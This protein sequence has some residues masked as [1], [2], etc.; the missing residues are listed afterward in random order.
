MD[1]LNRPSKSGQVDFNGHRV[2]LMI[3]NGML[4]QSVDEV[5]EDAEYYYPSLT[6]LELY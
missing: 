3:A 4:Q 2:A 6:F 5:V 1:A